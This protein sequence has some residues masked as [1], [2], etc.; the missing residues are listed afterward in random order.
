MPTHPTW[1]LQVERATKV[2]VGAAGALTRRDAAG[3]E[4]NLAA[5]GDAA[6]GAAAFGLVADH[7]SRRTP[8]AGSDGDLRPTHR[9]LA[10]RSLRGDP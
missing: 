10:A 7:R 9:A 2:A 8:P 4:S 3:D 1:R 6:L 5:A